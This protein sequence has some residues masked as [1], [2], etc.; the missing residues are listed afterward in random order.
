MYVQAGGGATA[1]DQALHRKCG[2]PPHDS[3]CFYLFLQIFL[4]VFVCLQ[5]SVYLLVA[6]TSL[7]IDQLI[8]GTLVNISSHN[9]LY[10]IGFTLLNFVGLILI[11]L[12]ILVAN[13]FIA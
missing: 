4:G 5:M 7:W 10:L 11:H 2:H 6:A 13:S 9:T 12:S 1:P 3:Q 8:N